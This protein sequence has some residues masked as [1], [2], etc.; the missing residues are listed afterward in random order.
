MRQ[1]F[2]IVVIDP[3]WP[4]RK[5]NIRKVRPNQ[6][7]NLDYKTLSEP[8]IFTLLDIDIFLNVAENNTVFLWTVDEFL[9]VAEKAMTER[10]YRQHARIIWDKM[11]GP[12][13]AFTIRY[14]HEYLLWFYFG[15]FQTVAKDARGIFRTVLHEKPRQHSRKPDIAYRMIETLYPDTQR[16]DVFSREARPGWAQYG[17]QTDMFNVTTSPPVTQCHT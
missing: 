17:D 9:Q 4:K 6:T 13:P 1:K 3:P 15:K 8:E 11:N 5:G 12:A 16:I 10:G 7:R 14:T 2:D